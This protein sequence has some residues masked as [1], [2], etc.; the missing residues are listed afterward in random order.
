[1][2]IQPFRTGPGIPTVR[3]V[4][5]VAVTVPDLDE[6]AQFFIEVLGCEY[7]YD[8][9][10]TQDQVGDRMTERFNVPA[11]SVLKGVMLRCGPSLNLEVYEY[12]A[13]DQHQFM[14]RNCDWGAVH[15]ALFVDDI[16]AAYAYLEAVPGVRMLG[17]PY[18]V[19]RGPIATTKYVYFLTPWGMQMEIVSYGELP[20]TAQTTIRQYGPA[21]QWS[22]RA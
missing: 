1:M 6:A 8:L 17:K 4:D 5:H 20:Y 2:L 22:S 10:P 12:W 14:P 3:N 9:G 7:I 21:D 19:P 13:P 16:D 15:F 18:E 11:R